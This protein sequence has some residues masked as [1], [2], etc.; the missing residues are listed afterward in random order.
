MELPNLARY[1]RVKGRW[2]LVKRAYLLGR[3]ETEVYKEVLESMAF[4]LRVSEV[5]MASV[6]VEKPSD[7]RVWG[8][9]KQ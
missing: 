5:C 9:R 1:M 6:K 4:S 8:I 2:S 3:G 7:P